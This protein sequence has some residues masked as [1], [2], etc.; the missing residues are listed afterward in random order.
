[1][2][3]MLQL[4]SWLILHQRPRSV[5]NTYWFNLSM[6]L[7]KQICPF[8]SMARTL[9]KLWWQIL[10]LLWWIMAS[11]SWKIPMPGSDRVQLLSMV[12]KNLLWTYKYSIRVY[13]SFFSHTTVSLILPL[14]F[15]VLSGAA[16]WDLVWAG[17][18]DPGAWRYHQHKAG[19]HRPCWCSPSQWRSF[20]N[21][22]GATQI[23]V[24]NVDLLRI[25]DFCLYTVEVSLNWTCDTNMMRNW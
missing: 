23:F 7:L 15:F 12:F 8:S 20:K 10:L 21:W 16:W 6:L 19:W 17:C 9:H 24:I 18:C 13:L 25:E 4:P 11:S 2:L 1:M 14:S 22:P 5:L 3:A